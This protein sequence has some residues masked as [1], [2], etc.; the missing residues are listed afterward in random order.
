MSDFSILATFSIIIHYF[1]IEI[2]QIEIIVDSES[3]ME[4]HTLE[5][6]SP[7]PQLTNHSKMDISQRTLRGKRQVF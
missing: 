3:V 7:Y 5:H 4:E 1:Q 6:I 2:G